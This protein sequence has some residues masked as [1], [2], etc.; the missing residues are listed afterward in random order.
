MPLSRPA[1]SF[2][3]WTLPALLRCCVGMPT[4]ARV[5]LVALVA[6]AIVAVGVVP[7]AL[8]SGRTAEPYFVGNFDSCNFSQW[9]EQGPTDAFHISL[10]PRTEGRCAAVLT[11]GPAA[12]GG[13][14]NQSSD[15]VALW[16]DLADYGTSGH[17]IWQHFS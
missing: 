15:G 3:G 9:H 12:F 6:L 8:G 10:H 14:V 4:R 13:L 17:A 16:T 2:E 1:H 5:S 11:V 7:S